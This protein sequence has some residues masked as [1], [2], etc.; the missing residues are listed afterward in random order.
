[1]FNRVEVRRSKGQEYE[2]YPQ[3]TC[4]GKRVR[5]CVAGIRIQQD[6]NLTVAITTA[7]ERQKEAERFTGLS[8]HRSS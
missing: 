4:T 5:G 2:F 8:R 3:I 1:M 6:E 7:D